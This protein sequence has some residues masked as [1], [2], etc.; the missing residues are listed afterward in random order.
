MS[1]NE[2]GHINKSLKTQDIPTPKILIKDHN[3]WTSM[4]HFP[5]RLLIPETTFSDTFAKV[6]NL[7]LKNILEKNEINDTKF[8]IVQTS[9]IKEE[10]YILNWKKN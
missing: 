7:G 6:G 1:R 4:R 2:V 5:T 3:E 9:Q 10:R 8:T